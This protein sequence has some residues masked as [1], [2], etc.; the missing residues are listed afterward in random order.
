MT[1]APNS[2]LE[3]AG[4][5][6]PRLAERNPE[7]ERIGRLHDETVAELKRIG[8]TRVFQ[9]A[10]FGGLELD[11]GA[12]IELGEVLAR[13]CG[14]AA[15]LASVV[16]SQ[17]YLV[18]RFPPEAQEEVWGEGGDPLIV[19]ATA[20][21]HGTLRWTGDGFLLSG[22][23]RFTSCVDHS[24][25]ALVSAVLPDADGRIGDE[26]ICLIPR[27]DYRPEGEW[28]VIGLN[29]TGSRDLVAEDV[30]VPPHRAVE[31]ERLLGADPP[32]SVVHD[33]YLYRADVGSLFGTSILG[34]VLGLARAGYEHYRWTT[35]QRV[36]TVFGDR[37]AESSVVQERLAHSAAEIDAARRIAYDVVELQR[38]RL[39]EGSRLTPE[40]HATVL[41]DRAWATRT[42]VDALHRL[43]RSTGAAGLSASDRATAAFRDLQAAAA[44]IAVNWD[45]NMIAYG[46]FALGLRTGV[47]PIDGTRGSSLA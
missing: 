9:P 42:C 26:W 7:A 18:A 4:D 31:A 40:E 24:D 5:L 19:H 37:V 28:R 8:V 36:G 45:R 22:H 47:G 25:W 30:Y 32:G 1:A 14:S 6:V 21:N 33:H 44:Q 2:L 27:R 38:R 16:A 41:R 43:V 11:W 34:P 15:W 12:Q 23:W 29:G 39:A 3:E 46:R 17:A 13:G 35:S 10:K 20:T